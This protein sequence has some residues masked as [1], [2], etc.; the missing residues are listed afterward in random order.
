MAL[1]DPLR[2]LGVSK[3]LFGN[4][5]FWLV[6]GG[7]AWG[8]RAISWARHTNEKTLFRQVIEPGETLVISASGPPWSRRQRRWGLK[9]ERMLARRERR[10]QVATAR[11]R[12][13]HRVL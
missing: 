7:A 10:E 13:R 3:G 8:L 5:R 11:M 4:S 2:A 9:G 6:I 1:L 12:H